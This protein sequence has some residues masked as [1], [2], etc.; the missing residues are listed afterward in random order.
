MAE[1]YSISPRAENNILQYVPDMEL[2]AAENARLRSCFVRRVIVTP[3]LFRWDVELVT[4]QTL[5]AALLSRTEHYLCERL[6]LRA[7]GF[8]QQVTDLNRVV[9]QSWGRIVELATTTPD[10]ELSALRQVLMSAKAKVRDDGCVVVRL[11][12]RVAIGRGLLDSN[13][14]ARLRRAIADVSGCYLRVA[15]EYAAHSDPQMPS[16]PQEKLPEHLLPPSV[17]KP[18]VPPS[19][20]KARREVK[21]TR[22]ADITTEMREVVVLGTLENVSGRSMRETHLLTFDVADESDGISGKR[23]YRDKERFESALAT[24]R[25]GQRVR[26]KGSVRFDQYQN[27]LVLMATSLKAEAATTRMD[28]APERRIELHA[29]TQ[30]SD[31]DAVV[32][33]RQ[34]VETAARWRWDAIAI[35]DH[36][37]VQAFPEAM[38]TANKLPELKVIYG[39][40][41][42][43]IPGD[44]CK[45]P[46]HHIILLVR[47]AVG[48]K[49]LYKL[50]SRSHLDYFYRRP[51]IP[52][53][54]LSELREGII[55]GSACEAGELFRA[56]VAGK[57]DDELAEIAAF[58][59]Y[60]E[61]QPAGNNAFMLRD[62]ERYPNIKSEDD[63]RALNLKV[64][65]LAEKLG[66]PLVATGD[67]HFLNPDDRVYRAIIQQSKGYA[68]ADNQPPLYLKTTDE[69]L[70]E[71]AYLGEARARAAV[72]DNPHRIAEQVERLK[73]IPDEF[74]PPIIEGAEATIRELSYER[75]HRWYGDPLPRIVQARLEQELTPI[76]K[77]GFSVLYLIAQKLVKKSNED[78][79]LVGSRGSVG[80][81]FI[82]TVTGIS[83]V[84]PLP[85]H[86]R[87][88]NCCYSDFTAAEGVRSGYDLPDRECPMCGTPLIKDGQNIEFATFLGFDGDKVPDID[89]NFASVYQARA[90]KYTESLFSKDHSYRAGTIS[91]V[92]DKT[93]FGLA[94]HYYE[95][96]GEHKRTAFLGHMVRGLVGT[97]RTTGQHPAGIMVVPENKDIH[98]F[99]P[100]QY[101]ANK[102]DA[103]VITTHFDYH[104][105]T[106]RL[107]KLDNL[108]HDDPTMLR[109]LE[110]LT[111]RDVRSIPFDDAATL[112]LFNSTDALGVTAAELGATSGTF[113]IPEFR[114][115]FTRQMIDDIHPSCFNDLVMIS[116]FSHGTNVWLDN[117]QALI[118]SGTK[119]SE[120]ISARDDIMHQLMSMG[121]EPLLAFKTMEKVRK[122]KGIEA[123]VVEKFRAAGVPEWYIASCQ[124]IKYLFPRAH[125]AAYVMMAYRIAYFKVHYPLAYYA[126]HFSIRA[127]TFDVEVIA[128]GK[129]A[130]RRKLEQLA[131]IDKPDDK[132]K[133]MIVV[134]QLAWELHLRGFS[135]AP[136][137]LYASQP[138]DF[139]VLPGRLLPSL[140][141]MRGFGLAAA[142][143]LA[144]ARRHGK[145]TSVDDLAQRTGLNKANLESL[146][147]HGCLAGLPENDQIALF[148]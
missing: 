110:N 69:M 103:G 2:S 107:V 46:S 25:D 7:V 118:R 88:P 75:A 31:M 108:G 24:F 17:P 42:Y 123:Q 61:I 43:L 23:F 127:D 4:P 62:N 64:A 63:L 1:R 98:D 22:I 84:N 58:Y 131:A 122:G 119:V 142:R 33:A 138:E 21:L 34:L 18:S 124:K 146:R 56:I 135:V 133:E 99:T 65:E 85:P 121:V 49:N 79:Y 129:E 104:S 68:D 101:P 66:K 14:Q 139:T 51:R 102:K 39:L 35:T 10:K 113:G 29:H 125:A 19:E 117:A 87:C 148:A 20:P 78:G 89:L 120:V 26:V 3:Q 13:N 105:I 132:Q 93:A 76:T 145:F 112:S 67:V 71:F 12:Q 100:L 130:I 32:S 40:E 55:V 57:P 48:L 95:E 86:Y 77:H 141:A 92:K 50:V 6:D 9:Q 109:M 52:R 83:E 137:D 27:D 16:L 74:Y 80:S 41:G 53:H 30:M 114:T 70:A 91:T 15:L 140:T 73:P 97:K 44:D 94:A 116:G 8:A 54:V 59:D 126:A 106:E 143:K 28:D 128:A 38:Q 11:G 72:I 147:Q 115:K 96:H 60:L 45:Q 36:G 90:Q 134:L 144:Q 136:I 81:S 47:N 82:A 37:V 111:H 5:D